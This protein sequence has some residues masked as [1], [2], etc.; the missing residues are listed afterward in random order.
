[1]RPPV[2]APAFAPLVVAA[3]RFLR[4]SVRWEV[5]DRSGTL[6]RA[7]A[8]IPMIFACRHGQLWPLLW[9]VRDCSVSV[10]VSRSGDGELLARVLEAQGFDLIR[11]SSSR[12]ATAAAK[13]A[14]RVLRAGGRVG[15]A[16]DGPRGPRGMVRDGILRIAQ[17]TGVE[18]VPLRCDGA[19]PWVIPGT[20]DA[21]EVPRPLSRPRIHVLAPL[22]VEAGEEGLTLA[23]HRLAELLDGYRPG[24]A[25]S[26][27]TEWTPRTA[28][29]YA[30]P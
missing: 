29:S 11:G 12:A 2:E 21:F 7:A 20:W 6:Q 24:G 16:I 28:D 5:T 9:A 10:V 14:M 8:G 26:A 4:W 13:G 19:R 30:G 1:M 15:M 22:R 27:G 3:D 23:G 18:V 17:H 25:A